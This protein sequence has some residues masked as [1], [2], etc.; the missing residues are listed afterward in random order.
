MAHVR[1]LDPGSSALAYYG[2]EL[3]RLREAAGL[4]QKQVG[5]IIYCTGSLVGQ[6]ETAK[7]PPTR[8]FTERA[9]AAL[10]ADGAL[11]RIWPLVSRSALPGWFRPYADL[12]AK[13]TA[14]YTFQVQL[15]HGLLQTE[16]YARAV[17]EADRPGNLDELVAGRMERQRILHNENAP[18]LWMIIGEGVLHQAIGGGPIMRNQLARLLGYRKHPR[19]HVQVLPFIAGA[20]AG[21]PGSF[22]VLHFEKLPNIAYTEDYGPGNVSFNSLDVSLRSHRYDLLQAAALSLEDSAEL[23]A[24]VM[25]DRYGKDQA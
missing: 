12:E 13:A 10:G 14:I 25:E 18:F 11:L 21:L 20:H 23:I 1:D 7:K 24:E 19:I 9:D 15:V 6:I 2:S 4:T 22:N 8:T 17:L 16:D 3:R 5:D